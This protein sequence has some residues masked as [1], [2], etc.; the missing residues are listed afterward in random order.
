MSNGRQGPLSAS[1]T[2]LG[3]P[4]AWASS[5]RVLIGMHAEDRAQRHALGRELID[6]I[7]HRIVWSAFDEEVSV[8]LEEVERHLHAG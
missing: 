5:E 2:N 3:A 1:A 8:L 7:D 4:A 6:P